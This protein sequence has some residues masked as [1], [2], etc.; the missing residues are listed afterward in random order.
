MGTVLCQREKEQTFKKIE[1]ERVDESIKI[2]N[3]GSGEF[4]NSGKRKRV[5]NVYGRIIDTERSLFE[6]T[7]ARK[8]CHCR[9]YSLVLALCRLVY[10]CPCMLWAY[11]ALLPVEVELYILMLQKPYN[12]KESFLYYITKI[13]FTSSNY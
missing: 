1:R 3:N 2:I 12:D 10:M 8:L 6:N 4:E 9:K 11:Q 5:L 13:L 7:Y